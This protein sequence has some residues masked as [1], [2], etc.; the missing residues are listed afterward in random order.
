MDCYAL[1]QPLNKLQKTVKF[2]FDIYEP[3]KKYPELDKL[4]FFN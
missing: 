4:G 1:D 2:W 3:G